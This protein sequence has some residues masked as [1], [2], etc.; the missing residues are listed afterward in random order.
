MASLEAY[1]SLAKFLNDEGS[2]TTNGIQENLTRI[3]NNDY[4]PE[5]QDWDGRSITFVWD[6]K[7]YNVLQ[8]WRDEIQ[9]TDDGNPQ[10]WY[11]QFDEKD[12]HAI[13]VQGYYDSWADSDIEDYEF[14]VGKVTPVTV[15][16][17]TMVEV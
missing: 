5:G 4:C 10:W 3:I 12:E 2:E 15:K 13:F 8:G 14:K 7:E 9:R 1:K 16:Y 17:M 6:N 11:W